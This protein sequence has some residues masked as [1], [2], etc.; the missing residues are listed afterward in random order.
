MS[1]FLSLAARS[2]P[3]LVAQEAQVSPDGTRLSF[4]LPGI[5]PEDFSCFGQC[6]GSLIKLI[7]DRACIH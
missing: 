6:M 5:E 3:T 2:D 7:V 1:S 4:T